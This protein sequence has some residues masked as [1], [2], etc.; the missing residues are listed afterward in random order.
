MILKIILNIFP[1]LVQFLKLVNVSKGM[2]NFAGGFGLIFFSNLNN[3][4]EKKYAVKV[5]LT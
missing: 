3:E 4:E 2:M 5:L 1:Q